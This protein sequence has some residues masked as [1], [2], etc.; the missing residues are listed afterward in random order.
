MGE[1][2]KANKLSLVVIA[3]ALASFWVSAKAAPPKKG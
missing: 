2:K 3:A 1:S